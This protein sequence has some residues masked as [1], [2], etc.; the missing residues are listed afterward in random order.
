[1]CSETGPGG[2]ELLA[3][4]RGR[5]LFL[6]SLRTFTERASDRLIRVAVKDAPTQERMIEI[7]RG[8]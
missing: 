1:M 4:R 6:R 2:D 8:V 7:L 3:R 5:G